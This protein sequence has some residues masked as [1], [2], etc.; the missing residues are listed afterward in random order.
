MSLG[1]ESTSGHISQEQQSYALLLARMACI[2]VG[3]LAL[4]LFVATL[5]TYFVRL[6][7]LCTT[8]SCSFGQL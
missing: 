8:D 7:I 6:H 4:G 3:V 1:H 5:P 2:V